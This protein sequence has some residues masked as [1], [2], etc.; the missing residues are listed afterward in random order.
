MAHNERGAMQTGQCAT[1]GQVPSDLIYD[2]N[3]REPRSASLDRPSVIEF[4]DETLRDGLQCPSVLQPSLQEKKRFLR[5]L[6]LIGIGSADIG[7]AGASSATFEDVVELARTV[8][9]EHLGIKVNCAGR[10]HIDDIRPIAEAQ[11]RSGQAIDAALFIGSS[12]IRQWVEGWDLAALVET[13]DKALSYA[14]SA[15]LEVMFVTED[16]TRARPE[17]LATLYLAAAEA[18]ATRFC[19]S[20]TVGQAT[21]GGVQQLVSYLAAVLADGGFG[22]APIDWHGHRDRGLDV[23]NALAALSAGAAR[24]HGCA[25]GIGE[26]VGNTALDLVLVNVVLLGWKDIDL[27][28]LPEYCRIAGEMTGVAIPRNYPVIGQDAF[29]TSTGVHAAAVAKA[30]AKGDAWLADRVYSAVPASLVGR[31]QEISIGPMSGKANV[32]YWL[33]EHGFDPTPARLQAILDAA[34]HSPGVLD[35]AEA[36]RIAEAVV[37]SGRGEGLL[38]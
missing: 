24:V 13:I 10:T 26:R 7:Y 33:R 14:V 37:A 2:W 36:T 9:D 30:Y 38:I 6:P 32:L 22:S 19:I 17:D 11:Q 3:E 23:V 8:S 4:N 12:A 25:L 18:G 34:K 27:Q 1:S 31:R 16:T 15:G 20:D 28:A 21:P 29:A 35:D 5:L